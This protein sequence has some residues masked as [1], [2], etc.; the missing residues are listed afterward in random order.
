MEQTA[1]QE[2]R[3]H[4]IPATKQATAPG[5]A[6]GHKQRVAAY[7]RVSTDSEE[8][9]TSYTA[10]KAYYTQKIDE[11][12]D[13]EMAGIYADKGITGTSMKKRVEFKKMIAACKRGKIDLI[14]TK[15]LSRFARN[16]VDSLE[17]VR[18]LRANG[19][20]VIFE[21]ENINTL[22]ESSEFLLTLFSGFAQAE[23]ESISKNVIWGI[24]KSREAGNVPFQYQKLL[25]YRR[26]P[27]GQPEIVRSEAEVV[28]RIYR[29]YLDGCSLAQIKRE[30]EADGVPTSSG[31]QGWTYQVIRNILTNER[32]IGDAL[33]QKTYTTDC[34][35]KTVKKNQG[36]RSM[37]YVEK[38]HP[39]IVSKAMFYQ[40]REEMARRGSKRK[41]MQKTGKTEQGKYSAK[42]ALS[43]L[44]VCGECGTPYKRCTWTRNG[45]KRIVWRCVSRLEFGTKYCHDSPSMDEDKL[46]Q[47][48]L[49]SINEFVQAG[50][51]LGDELLD[52]ASIVQQGG[53]A[54]GIDPLTL[55][56]RLD[57]LTAQQAELLD[58]VLEDM[59]NEELNAQ[60]KATMEEKQAILGRLGALQQD[61]EQRAGQEAR[62]RELAEWLKKQ[63]SEFAEYDD[64]ITRRYVERITVV[65]A[66]TIRIKFRYTD[67][68]IDR[69]VRT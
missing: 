4:V 36:E 50:Q 57:A 40:V 58:K 11:N 46:H 26:G 9:L 41:V 15:S 51:G 34:I 10:Q 43:E 25:G 55:R 61:E 59:E 29:R 38:N 67:V 42:Y 17:V 48:I 21:K 12:P 2:R 54:D 31:I 20:G 1:Q 23:S 65:D 39:A 49:E 47:A 6:S 66:E 69:A 63:K 35:S 27:D 13:W 44:L 8:Q 7:C 32:Y 30:L 3:I 53:S 68:E 24:Q 28:K 33:L 19:I 14:L 5:R 16:T 62:L 56:N 37:V 18:M 64:S 60:L 52:L 22:T 45:K